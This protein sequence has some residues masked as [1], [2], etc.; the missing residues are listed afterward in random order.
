MTNNEIGAT[1]WMKVKRVILSL[2]KETFTVMDVADRMVGITNKQLATT[3]KLGVANGF[4]EIVGEVTKRG[5]GVPANL[6]SVVKRA[7]FSFELPVLGGVW[8]ELTMRPH[9]IPKGRVHMC[10]VK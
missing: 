4:L 6:Y 8:H 1:R 5:G 7:E 3:L 9:P 2:E 10:E